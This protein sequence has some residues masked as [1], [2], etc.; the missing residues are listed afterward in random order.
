MYELKMYKGVICHDNEDWC[1]TGGGI[2]L[3]LQNWHKEFD[4]FW[5][6]YLNISKKFTLMDSF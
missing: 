4:K 6:E 2:D 5:P 1:K 3:L